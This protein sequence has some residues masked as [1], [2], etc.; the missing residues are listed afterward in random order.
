MTIIELTPGAFEELEER[1]GP[2]FRFTDPKHNNNNLVLA[3]PYTQR[4]LLFVRIAELLVTTDEETL[5]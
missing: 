3:C 2:E 1:L 5:H 4:R